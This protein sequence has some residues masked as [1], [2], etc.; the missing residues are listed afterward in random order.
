MDLNQFSLMLIMLMPLLTLIKCQPIIHGVPVHIIK[1]PESS[2]QASV[3]DVLDGLVC[4]IFK[5]ILIEIIGFNTWSKKSQRSISLRVRSDLNF[6][7]IG[8]IGQE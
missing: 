7:K 2:N 5:L 3:H 1:P 4:M 8:L 6:K